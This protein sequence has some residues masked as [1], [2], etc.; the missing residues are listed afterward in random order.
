MNNLNYQKRKEMRTIEV[1][2][3]LLKEKFVYEK[4]ILD[5]QK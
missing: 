2:N 3:K 4:S 5:E 1:V